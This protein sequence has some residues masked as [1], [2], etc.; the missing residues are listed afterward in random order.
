MFLFRKTVTAEV[1]K[2]GKAFVNGSTDPV[3]LLVA[4]PKMNKK[5][6]P[7][8]FKND[9]AI[10]VKFHYISKLR[11]LS[12]FIHKGKKK[13]SV[14]IEPTMFMITIAGI[15]HT[16]KLVLACEE[17]LLKLSLNLEE[18]ADKFRDTYE[19]QLIHNYLSDQLKKNNTL[20]EDFEKTKK[21]LMIA[22]V[23]KWKKDMDELS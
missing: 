6:F 10:D 18:V 22:Y 8:F 14:V 16:K 4:I 21:D 2:I 20:V 11:A 17:P 9:E 5:I 1:V 19:N 15:M 13:L 3:P 12:L 23:A 7:D